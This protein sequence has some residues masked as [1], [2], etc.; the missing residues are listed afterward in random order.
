MQTR[1]MKI[2]T[3]FHHQLS[4]IFEVVH[5]GPDRIP[6]LTWFEI[7]SYLQDKYHMQGT[8]VGIT[9]FSKKK[10]YSYLL[11]YLNINNDKILL[12]EESVLSA[13]SAISLVRLPVCHLTHFA[14]LRG[15]CEKSEEQQLRQAQ[16]RWA[17]K[18]IK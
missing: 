9:S 16:K 15:V 17:I 13:C 8:Y 5:V 18:T 6:S 4:D 11:G 3:K 2:Y 10:D 1:I 12:S 14:T 7:L